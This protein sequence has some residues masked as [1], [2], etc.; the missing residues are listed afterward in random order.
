MQWRKCTKDWVDER[1]YVYVHVRVCVCAGMRACVS[2]RCTVAGWSG[3]LRTEGTSWAKIGEKRITAH[4]KSLEYPAGMKSRKVIFFN[5]LKKKRNE[6]IFSKD[7]AFIW[8]SHSDF[9][10]KVGNPEVMGPPLSILAV[11][12]WLGC[13]LYVC[14]P[15]LWF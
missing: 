11:G 15:D 13:F 6:R 1:V 9:Q 3:K 8:P 12:L 14:D 10:W 7:L 2:W 4:T 5:H